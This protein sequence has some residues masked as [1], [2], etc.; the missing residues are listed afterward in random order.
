MQLLIPENLNLY[1]LLEG[2]GDLSHIRR[3]KLVEKLAYIC[4]VLYWQI[5]LKRKESY[6][7]ST[8]WYSLNST[9]LQAFSKDYR[10][11]LNLLIELGVIN[12]KNRSYSSGS[13][14]M[15]YQFTKRYSLQNYKWIEIENYLVRKAL[16]K[17]RQVE[18]DKMRKSTKGYSFLTKWFNDGCLTIDIDAAS[19]WLDEYEIKL[20]KDRIKLNKS[21][22]MLNN[23]VT[24]LRLSVDFINSGKFR[25]K[26][27]SFGCRF[28]SNLTNLKEELRNYVKYDNKKLVSIDLKN[29]QPYLALLL[30]KKSFWLGGNKSKC[31]VKRLGLESRDGEIIE[32]YIGGIIMLVESLESQ[33][34]KGFSKNYPQLVSSGGFYEYLI[35]ELGD[36]FPNRFSSNNPEVSSRDVAKK[37]VLRIMY[38]HP[39]RAKSKFYSPCRG[40]ERLFPLEYKLFNLIKRDNYKLL[41]KLLQR[42]EKFLIINV[43][44]K[45]LNREYPDMPLFTVHDSIVSTE[46]NVDIIDKKMKQ[47]LLDEIGFHPTLDVKH[48]E[49]ALIAKNS[50]L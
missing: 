33:Y 43:I 41:P 6:E 2:V 22:V 15:K 10:Y 34:S 9:L 26:I 18:V 27:D 35:D 47:V 44:C 4:H 48:W 49:S 46:E 30:F 39:R 1:Q 8:E 31:W 3:S 24:G 11:E 45:E 25:Y 14:S 40:Y 36:E 21:N 42:I 23:V 13:Y 50:T 16:R 20:K 38:V 7:K 12:Q 5:N 28:H 29:S 19:E 37:E 32:K 17:V